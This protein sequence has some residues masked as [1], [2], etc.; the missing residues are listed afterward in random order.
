MYSFYFEKLEVWHLSRE[1][2]KSIYKLTDSFPVEER[3]GLISQIRR[4]SVS[5][6]NNLAEGSARKTQKDQASFTT[7]SYGSLLEVLNLLI[8]A[9]DLK[10]IEEEKYMELRPLIEEIAN[11]LNSLRKAQEAKNA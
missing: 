9:S 1:L 8:L 7:V 2:T 11:K 5:I 6:A 10:F 3:Y 4:A